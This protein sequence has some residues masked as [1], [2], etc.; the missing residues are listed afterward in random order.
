MSHLLDT[1]ICS[2]HF[3]RPGGLAHQFLQHVGRLFVPT[4]ALGELYAG[5][6]HV[7][8]PTDLLQ[9]IEDLLEDV[10]VLDFDPV[11]AKKFGEIRGSLLRQGISIP[12]VDLMIGSV[13]LVHD[14]TLVT[15]NTADFRNIPGIRLENWLLP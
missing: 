9:R 2:A 10:N 8:D 14:L 5:A 12:S 3:R 11:C 4:I 6:Y 13:A 1:N 15:H 7:S